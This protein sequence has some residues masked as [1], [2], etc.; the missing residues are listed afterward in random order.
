MNIYQLEKAVAKL[1]EKLISD[2]N[3]TARIDILEF[4]DNK[5]SLEYKATGQVVKTMKI[6]LTKKEMEFTPHNFL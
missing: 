4:N 5:M 1:K 6:S 2:G 3:D